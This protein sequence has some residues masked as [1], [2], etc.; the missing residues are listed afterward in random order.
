MHGVLVTMVPAVAAYFIGWV[1]LY[2]YLAEFGISSSELDLGIETVFI[3]SWP[4]IKILLKL[5]WSVL[6]AVGVVLLALFALDEWLGVGFRSNYGPYLDRL[7]SHI[8][9]AS[10]LAQGIYFFVAL[11][12]LAFCL[13]PLIQMAAAHQASQK[14]EHEG[15]PIMVLGND[16]DRNVK[17]HINYGRCA[18]RGALDLIIADA[19]SYY[20]LCRSSI[21]KTAA[22]VFEVRRESGLASVRILTR[23]R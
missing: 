9:G 11:V 23:E 20:I 3:Y 22:A 14:W 1:Y 19:E 18:E 15:V 10:L 12:I 13:T 16:P 8:A 2:Y 21:T 5:Y 4:P 17:E 7:Q 6:I